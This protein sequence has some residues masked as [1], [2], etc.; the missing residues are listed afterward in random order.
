MNKIFWNISEDSPLKE[1]PLP[2]YQKKNPSSVQSAVLFAVNGDHIKKALRKISAEPFTEKSIF[3]NRRIRWIRR[4]RELSPASA[5]G[6]QSFSIG[7]KTTESTAGG[8]Q[9]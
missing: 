8:R 6:R 3:F 1:S 9:R 2:L 4:T 7:G 5:L